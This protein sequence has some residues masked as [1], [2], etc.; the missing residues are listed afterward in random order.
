VSAKIGIRTATDLLRVFPTEA[1]V[2]DGTGLDQRQL[3]FLVR[4]LQDHPSLAPVW[5]WKARGVRLATDEPGPDLKVAQLPERHCGD[6]RVRA[7]GSDRDLIRADVM[8]ARGA[9]ARTRTDRRRP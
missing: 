1:D 7:A 4:A 9:P 2:G 5:N 8:S 6:A 3:K